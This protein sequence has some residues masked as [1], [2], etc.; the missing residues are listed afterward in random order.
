MTVAL[1]WALASLICAFTLWISAVELT[2]NMLIS[3]DSRAATSS[4]ITVNENVPVGMGCDVDDREG[5]VDVD[6]LEPGL[7]QNTSNPTRALESVTTCRTVLP[8]RVTN[9]ALEFSLKFGQLAGT[10]KG[11]LAYFA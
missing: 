4:R 10:T 8:F 6:E 5:V 9:L 3:M 11:T 7:L 1:P 2:V